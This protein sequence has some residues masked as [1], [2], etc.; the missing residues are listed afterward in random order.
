MPARSYEHTRVNFDTSGCT[1]LHPMVP[2]LPRPLSSTTVGSPEPM[3]R[4]CTLCPPTSMSRP[5]GGFADRSLRV[6][7]HWYA[8]PAETATTRRPPSPTSVRFAQRHIP[9]LPMRGVRW[10]DRHLALD[11]YIAPHA[12]SYRRMYSGA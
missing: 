7:I 6:V 10:G 1:R 11:A 8:A 12:R 3:Q 5:G 2:A 9:G 4:I